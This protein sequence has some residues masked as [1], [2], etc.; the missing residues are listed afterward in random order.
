MPH[1]GGVQWRNPDPAV[2]PQV[3]ETAAAGGL[4]RTD[5]ADNMLAADTERRQLLM[6]LRDHIAE[7]AVG[8]LPRLQIGDSVITGRRPKQEKLVWF[9]RVF[10]GCCEGETGP[11]NKSTASRC[12]ALRILSSRLGLPSEACEGLWRETL[13]QL[14]IR[15]FLNS[16]VFA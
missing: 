6:S 9:G 10:V 12:G 11:K 5:V 13:T 8:E 7:G 15:V 16:L 4:L 2:R 3:R 1:V 14:V